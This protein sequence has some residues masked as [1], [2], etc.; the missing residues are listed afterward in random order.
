MFCDNVELQNVFERHCYECLPEAFFRH[1]SASAHEQISTVNGRCREAFSSTSLFLTQ[2]NQEVK[3]ATRTRQLEC[4]T[5]A[6]WRT[7][8]IMLNLRK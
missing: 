4:T 1:Q 2:V 5:E 6:G 7:L 3:A 8:P